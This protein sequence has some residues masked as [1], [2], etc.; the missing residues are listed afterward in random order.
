MVPVSPPP[1]PEAMS[2]A[3][4]QASALLPADPRA[5]LAAA[6]AILRMAPH[7]PRAGLIAASAHRRLGET[8]QALALLRP[9]AAAF[10]KAAQTQYELGLTLE[11]RGE[12]S[13]AIS[14][15]RAAT[16]ARSDFVEAWKALGEA[17]FKAGNPGEAEAA[18][19]RADRLSV[20]DP[21]L[22]PAADALHSGDVVRAEALL[23]ARLLAAP[24]D[25]EAL[26]LLGEALLRRGRYAEAADAFERRLALSADDPAARFGLASA[27]F[28]QQKAQEALTH[29][30]ALLARDPNAPPYRNLAAAVFGL[31]GEFDRAI[32]I[33]TQLAAD[34]PGQPRVWLNHG[35]ALRTVGRQ[36]EAVEAY[37]KAI[38]LAPHLGDAWWSLANLKV[39]PLTDR[40]VEA[41]SQALLDPALGMEDRLHL[42]YALGKALEDR[43][44]FEESFSHYLAGA[45]A[46]RA[47]APYDPGLE[48]RLAKRTSAWFASGAAAAG[49]AG[50][51][52]GEVIFIVGL[53]RSGSTLVEQILASH[54]AVE[55]VMELPDLGI[56]AD[57]LIRG[58]GGGSVEAYPDVLARLPAEALA[59]LGRDYEDRTRIY[60][61]TQRPRFIDKM[62]N[63][64]RHLALIRA[65]LPKARV[66]DVRRH[67]MAVGFAAFKQHFNQGQG[68]SYDLA[69]IGAYYRDYVALM[70]AVDAACPGFVHRVIYEDL[71]E[72]AEGEIRRLLAACGLDFEATCLTFWRTERAVRTVSSEQVRRP[73]F[74]DALE[75]WR[76]YEAWLGPLRAALGP[77]LEDWRG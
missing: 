43:R 3:L 4:N 13:D 42:H 76:N 27:L 23:R 58:P 17:L 71:V 32:E 67:P 20:R 69:D 64:F 66:I 62:P 61:R 8:A 28:H 56:L 68:F 44:R 22:G 45:R 75:H 25:L 53:P 40:E 52:G 57:G 70:R 5:A 1:S 55:G 73:L 39:A 77:A 11:L 12:T 54:S 46:R 35:H 10:P 72:D 60:R 21:A 15:L 33:N 9:L 26:R 59:Q 2:Q 7:D 34:F 14:A 6:R 48:S 19:A 37:R 38:A 30:R 51:A 18:F 74:R 49:G 29:A 31:L 65:A 16:A 41:M 47:L 24:Q 50:A 63:N 36:S